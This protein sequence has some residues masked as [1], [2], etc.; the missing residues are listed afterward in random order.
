MVARGNEMG[1]KETDDLTGAMASE[2]KVG[3]IVW[4]CWGLNN[5]WRWASRRNGLEGRKGSVNEWDIANGIMG[6]GWRVQGLVA[7]K[8][9]VYPR[10]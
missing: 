6:W 4:S 7:T 2:K 1:K 8:S 10:E 5:C 9:G 3:S